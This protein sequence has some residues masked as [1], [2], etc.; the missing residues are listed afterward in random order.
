[1]PSTFTPAPPEVAEIARDI[2]VNHYPD[3]AEGEADP[4]VPSEV[5]PVSINFLM[6]YG[7]NGPAVKHDG[8][9]ADATVKI[10]NLRDRAEG[11][12]NVTI[13]IDGDQWPNWTPEYRRALIHHEIAHIKVN[14]YLKGKKIGQVIRQKDGAPGL[15]CEKH[16]IVIGGFSEVAGIYG[17]D[18]PEV[19]AWR[20]IRARHGDVLEV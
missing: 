16:D 5:G 13:T 7:D 11:K 8:Y 14:R 9:P 12:R 20:S 19:K 15:Y 17:A 4:N 10:N 18:S 2:I 6:A 1:M 3:L